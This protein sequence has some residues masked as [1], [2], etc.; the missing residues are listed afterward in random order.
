MS[1]FDNVDWLETSGEPTKDVAPPGEYEAKIISCEKY[2]SKSS[3]NW[4]VR[5]IFDLQNGAF[6][7]HTEYFSLWSANADAKRI[8]NEQFT[9]LC[10]AVGFKQFPNAYGDFVNKHLN[11]RVSN[12]QDSFKNEFG[13]TIEVTKTTVRS[14]VHPESSAGQSSGEPAAKAKPTL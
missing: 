7:E 6:R 12:E 11:I 8:S 2:Q 5:V 13:E 10:K 3:D 1:D 4:S 14:F 9:S